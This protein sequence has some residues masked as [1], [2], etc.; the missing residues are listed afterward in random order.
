[1]ILTSWAASQSESFLSPPGNRWLH[2][3]QAAS[4]A[5]RA[6]HAAPADDHD[7]LIAAAFLHDVGYAP[8]L[9]QTGFHPLDGARWI[10]RQGKPDRLARLVAH[11]SCAIYEARQR[12]LGEELLAEF[13]PENSATYDALVFF[14]MNKWT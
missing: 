2:V 8:E 3:Q 1:M 6:I 4:Q 12:G 7:L 10:R 5:K 11:H 14:D 9:A 13:S